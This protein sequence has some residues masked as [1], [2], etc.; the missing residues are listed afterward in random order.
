MKVRRNTAVGLLKVGTK[1]LFLNT[2]TGWTEMEPLC[3]LDFYVHESCQR[4]G[5]GRDLF[6]RMLADERISPAKLGYDRPS[7]K[8]F[9]FLAKHYHL[10]DYAPQTNNFVVFQRYFTDREDGPPKRQGARD[11]PSYAQA[12]PDLARAAPGAPAQAPSVARAPAPR[13]M[14]QQRDDARAQAEKLRMEVPGLG[15]PDAS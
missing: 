4:F 7:P 8:L 15:A 3:V 10:V 5:H 12:Q 9:G 6:E 11:P 2:D 1:K 13:S 14:A